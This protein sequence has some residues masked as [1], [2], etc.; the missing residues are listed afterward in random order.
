MKNK[1]KGLLQIILILA[2][3]GLC[4]F[5][6]LVGFTKHHKG[7]AQNIKLG[8]DLAGGLPFCSGIMGLRAQ[9]LLHLV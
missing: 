1:K 5:T 7:S 3:I 6:T 2:I 8:L 9:F 4:G